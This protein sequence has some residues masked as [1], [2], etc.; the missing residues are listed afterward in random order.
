MGNPV[1][2]A[3]LPH[4]ESKGQNSACLLVGVCVCTCMCVC[5]CTCVCD[6]NAESGK[7]S[8]RCP[9]HNAP[10]VTVVPCII[11]KDAGHSWLL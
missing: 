11:Y 5:V 1:S 3:Q 7:R 2:K 6:K 10:G 4:L 8:A 9:A